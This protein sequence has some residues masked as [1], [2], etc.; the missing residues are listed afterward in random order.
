MNIQLSL[1]KEREI[2]F[3]EVLSKRKDLRALGTT[4]AAKKILFDFLDSVVPIP[5]K[6]G[7][8]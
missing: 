3:T 5:K 1:P 4:D 7:E 2:Q 8:E 6:E